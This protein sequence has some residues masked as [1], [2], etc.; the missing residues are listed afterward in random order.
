MLRIFFN[1]D[2]YFVSGESVEIAQRCSPALTEKGDRIFQPLH[3][4]Y[5]VLYLALSEVRNLHIKEDVIVYNDSRIIDEINGNTP[6]LDNICSEWLNVIRRRAIPNIKSVVFFRKKPSTVIT[7][8]IIEAHNAMLEKIT[9]KQRSD[10]M[11]RECVL[12]SNAVKVTKNKLLSRFKEAWFG[13]KD[14]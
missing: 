5:K 12:R 7:S 14:L 1:E 10:L 9:N 6:P 2:G 4:T 3:H 11:S 8:T 13:K